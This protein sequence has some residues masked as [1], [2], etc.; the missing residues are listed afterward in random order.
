MKL[1]EYDINVASLFILK[2]AYLTATQDII[3]FQ[4]TLTEKKCEICT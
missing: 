2:K 4:T 1:Y 3:V